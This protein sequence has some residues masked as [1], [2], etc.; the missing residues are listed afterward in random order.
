MITDLQQKRDLSWRQADQG[1]AGHYQ[2]PWEWITNPCS[3]LWH[4]MTDTQ[5]GQEH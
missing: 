5:K 2:V 1:H 3:S 4:T